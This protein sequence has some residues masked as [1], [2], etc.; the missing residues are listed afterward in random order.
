MPR[1]DADHRKINSTKFMPKPARHRPGLK[2][3]ALRLWRPLAKQCRERPRVGLGLSLEQD[4]AY[5]VD[6]TY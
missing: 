3:D 4:L 6:H 5:F 1:V 2:S